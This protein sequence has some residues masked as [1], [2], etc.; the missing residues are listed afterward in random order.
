MK[1]RNWPLYLSFFCSVLFSVRVKATSMVYNFKVA[2]ITKQRTREHDTQTP[3]TFTSLLFYQSDT[4]YSGGVEDFYIGDLL[5]FVYDFESNNYFRTDCAVS[6]VNETVNKASIFTDTETDDILFSVGHIFQPHDKTSVTISGLF[7]I[8]THPVYALQHA[9]FGY[10]L[11]GIGAQLDG[12]YKVG[13][14]VDFI[15]GSRYLYFIPRTAQDDVEKS[16][17]FSIGNVA[18]VL[19]AL[20]SNWESDHCIEGGYAARWDFGA[21][22]SPYVP[23]V[24]EKTNYTKNSFYAVYKYFF[25]TNRV[26]HRVLLDLAYGFDS[27]PKIYGNR[28]IITAWVSWTLNF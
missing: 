18:D 22:I 27:K 1:H 11:V 15:W 23:G 16:Y 2:Q 3:Y 14:S 19:V 7:G 5:A 24:V 17:T 20:K 9:A 26:L 25:E 4:R 12:L 28:R 21:K 13:K 8:P 10:G 6:H